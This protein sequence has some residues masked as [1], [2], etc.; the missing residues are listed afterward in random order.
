VHGRRRREHPGCLAVGWLGVILAS[1]DGGTTWIKRTSGTTNILSGVTCLTPKI[2][3]AVGYKGTILA[4]EDGGGSWATSTSGTNTTLKGI[5]CPTSRRCLV[6]G[7][8]VILAGEP[9]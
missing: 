3:L 4:S 7:D 6:V 1:N 5:A 8:G 2:C 9:A